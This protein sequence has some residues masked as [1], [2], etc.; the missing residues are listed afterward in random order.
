MKLAVSTKRNLIGLL[1][2][3]CLNMPQSIHTYIKAKCVLTVFTKYVRKKRNKKEKNPQLIPFLFTFSQKPKKI[4]NIKS[5]MK[6]RQI[7]FEETFL[8]G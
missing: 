6:T 3:K 2:K 1:V 7:N 8:G 5:K 4:R